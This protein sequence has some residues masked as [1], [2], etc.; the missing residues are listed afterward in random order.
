[1]GKGQAAV[2]PSHGE[3]AV[4]GKPLHTP[5]A[6]TAPEALAHPHEWQLVLTPEHVEELLRATQTA[7]ATNKAVPELTTA[8]F[9]LPSLGPKL[10]EI[11]DSV[12]TERGFYL[13]RGFPV[14]Q[15]TRQ[16]VVTAWYGIGLY[17]GVAR[18]QNAKGHVVGHVKNLDDDVNADDVRVY[19]TNAAQASTVEAIAP[20]HVD[21][22]DLVGL[23]C[24]KTAKQGGLSGWA[25][26]ISIYNKLLETRP[27]LVQELAKIYAFDK[28]GELAP[29]TKPFLTVPVLSFYKGR[30]TF[31]YNDKYIKD[32]QKFPDV[33]RLTEKQLEALQAVT[34]LA[35]SPDLHLEWDLQ[36]G[37]VQ[38]IYNWTQL[39]MRTAYIDQE[40]FDNR[41]HLLRLWISVPGANP[42][43]PHRGRLSAP[44]E[45]E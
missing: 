28:K 41:R 21:D 39:H 35:N 6:W 12:L 27:D 29:G 42:I 31:F 16:E 10:R 32:A 26:S 34:D 37:D 22:A 3:A 45:A 20:W 13:L 36:V 17:W 23:L 2:T 30:L 7:V 14:E 4:L 9:P 15:L 40:G 43:D 18:S 11:R 25:S 19:T 24:L 44:L 38:L 1:M 5:A 8:D 33:P